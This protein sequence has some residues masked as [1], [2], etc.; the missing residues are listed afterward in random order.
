MEERKLLDYIGFINRG[1]KTILIILS[2]FLVLIIGYIDY[3]TGTELSLSFFYLLP[4]CL[5]AFISSF[6]LVVA[7]GAFCAVVWL[8][9][10]TLGGRHYSSIF[11][12]IWN[13]MMRFSIYGVVGYVVIQLK[14]ALKNQE[15]I[16]NTDYLTGVANRRMFYD[17]FQVEMERSKRYNHP[18]SLIYLDIDNFKSINDKY[19]HAE[20][21]DSLALIATSL[22]TVIRMSDIV[23]RIGGD[24]FIILLPECDKNGAKQTVNKIREIIKSESIKN[25]H[26]E[27]TLSLGVLSLTAP[28][29]TQDDLINKVDDLMYQVKNQGKNGVSFSDSE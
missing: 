9:A 23:G 5:I 29:G 17:R 15:I 3:L 8:I 12:M 22:K 25:L 16:S 10:L 28:K 24:E 21:D 18:F 20:G 4:V 27:I 2:F 26:Q 13:G 1:N 6:G 11:S 19:G 14:Y 7:N